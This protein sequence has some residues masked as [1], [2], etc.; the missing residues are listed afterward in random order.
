MHMAV[1]S[2]RHSVFL[3][4]F[5]MKVRKKFFR[6]LSVFLLIALLYRGYL[7]FR[8]ADITVPS[9]FRMSAGARLLMSMDGFGFVQSESGEIPWRMSAQHADLYENK[10]AQ[11]RDIEIVFSGP[12]KRVV[13]L[14]GEAGTLD[15]SSGNASIRSGARE[16]RVVTSDGYLLTTNSLFW[17]SGERLVRTAEPFKLLGSKIYLEGRGLSADVDMST[18]A[19]NNHVKA[20]LLE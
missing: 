7:L 8:G 16:V 12:D 5:S 4:G 20:V 15:T 14:I 9:L 11:L 3:L 2:G 17:K 19:V 10:E 1:R 18:I 6:V 13:T